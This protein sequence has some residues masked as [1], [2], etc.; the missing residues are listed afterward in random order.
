M[1]KNNLYAFKIHIF[2]SILSLIFL[3]RFEMVTNS[4]VI[5]IYIPTMWTSVIIYYIVGYTKLVDQ[6]SCSRNFLSTGLIAIVG[7]IMLG[8]GVF[9]N[10]DTLLR[11]Y[12]CG[13]VVLFGM[14]DSETNLH[15]ELILI[16]RH[17][18]II[19][20]P[21]IIM[22]VGFERKNRLNRTQDTN[23]HKKTYNN[24]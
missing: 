14:P 20:L 19:L 11:L 22:W 16:L 21:G 5:L 17:F 6:G 24:Y 15:G 8:I 18:F 13:V 12:Y 3:G 10:S 9:G 7:L 4:T 1:I 2:I 23:K